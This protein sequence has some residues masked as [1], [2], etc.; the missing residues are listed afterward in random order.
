MN[1][2]NLPLRTN[3]LEMALNVEDSVNSILLIYLS[4]EN[5]DRK[6]ITNKSGNLSFK[7]KIDLL[8]DLDILTKEEHACF[9]Y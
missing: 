7:N 4:I 6:A 5:N 3:V 9:R 1:N 2:R 8:F